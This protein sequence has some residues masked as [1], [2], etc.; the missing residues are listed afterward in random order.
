MGV[1]LKPKQCRETQVTIRRFTCPLFSQR[2][3]RKANG[4]NENQWFISPTLQCSSCTPPKEKPVGFV[5]RKLQVRIQ[6]EVLFP[7]VNARF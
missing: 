4:Y 3:S 7:F 5:T 1:R 6:F 2:F